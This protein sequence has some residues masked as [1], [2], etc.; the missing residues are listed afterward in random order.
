METKMKLYHL[1]G[2]PYCAKAIAKIDELGIRSNID[3]I[4]VPRAHEAR[5]ELSEI[6]G[7]VVG[8]PTLVDG[9]TIIADDDD[10][11]IAYLDEKFATE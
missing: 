6:T 3:F 11:I 7:G 4:E 1:P 5:V 8:V 2:C 10:K 9:S